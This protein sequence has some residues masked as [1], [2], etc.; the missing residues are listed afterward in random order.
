MFLVQT[1][2]TTG[3]ETEELSILT[4]LVLFCALAS[5]IVFVELQ[6]RKTLGLGTFAGA[7]VVVH[8]LGQ[9]A[10]GVP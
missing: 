4:F 10:Q 9:R 5:A 7:R 1:F 3:P 6:G 2:A 8:S